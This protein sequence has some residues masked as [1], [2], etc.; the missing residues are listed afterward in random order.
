MDFELNPVISRK[1][2]KIKQ[3]LS[4]MLAAR[5]LKPRVTIFIVYPSLKPDRFKTLNI[6]ITV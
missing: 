2:A 3:D 4:K 1:Q 5:D 6:A